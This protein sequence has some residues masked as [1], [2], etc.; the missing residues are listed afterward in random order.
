MKTPIQLIVGLGNP[1]PQYHRTRHNAGADLVLKLAQQNNVSFKSESRFFGDTA[2]MHVGN[3]DVRLLLP[4]T[5]MNRS[6]QAVAAMAQFYRIPPQAI[7][8]VHDELD[9]PVGTARFKLA[10]G[11][12]GN[13][14]VRSVI[15]SLGNERNFAR[16]RIGIGHP[17]NAGDVTNYVLGKAPASEQ[18]QIDDSIDDALQLL[19]LAV[20]GD[21]Q[22]AMNKLHGK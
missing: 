7:L 22:Q 1:G 19:P 14:G 21:W 12:G 8:I 15:Q 2:R 16:L 18:Q 4:T 11:P 3:Q 6:G 17:G 10:G 9:L 13:N 5:Y 20:A